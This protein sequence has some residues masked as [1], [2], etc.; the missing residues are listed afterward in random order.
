MMRRLHNWVCALLVGMCTWD[1][2]YPCPLSAT[3]YHRSP[4][5]LRHSDVAGAAAKVALGKVKAREEAGSYGQEAVE[6]D[7]I[8]LQ[9]NSCVT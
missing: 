9:F 8:R 3:A 1:S 4:E 5:D 2:Q 6:L 7:S